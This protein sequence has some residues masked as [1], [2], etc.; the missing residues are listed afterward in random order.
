MSNATKP[1]VL[2]LTDTFFEYWSA[3]F[4]GA[5]QHLGFLKQAQEVY[6]MDRQ[7]MGKVAVVYLINDTSYRL[8]VALDTT[9]K[10]VFFWKTMD[11]QGSIRS[12]KEIVVSMAL[13]WNR[14]PMQLARFL[15]SKT[16]TSPLV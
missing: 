2:R 15:D 7:P 6:V 13:L 5:A 3:Y 11:A 9:S 4:A 10:V 1:T 12:T 16:S 14:S 8:D